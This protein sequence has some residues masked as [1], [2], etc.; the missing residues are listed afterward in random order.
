VIDVG[1]RRRLFTGA[2]R[3][4]VQVRDLGECFHDLCDERG[5]TIPDNGRVAC[6]THDRRRNRRNRRP[7]R[8][9]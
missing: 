9:P 3:R 2:D 6:G 1:V 4:A 7:L 5:A 8:G